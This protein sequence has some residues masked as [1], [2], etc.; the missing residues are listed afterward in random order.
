[1]DGLNHTDQVLLFFDVLVKACG[2][3]VVVLEHQLSRNDALLHQPL[4]L[5]GNLEFVGEEL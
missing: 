1:V 2:I 3:S 5:L 4:D